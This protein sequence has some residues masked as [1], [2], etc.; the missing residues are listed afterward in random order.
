MLYFARHGL[1]SD[2]LP[3]DAAALLLEGDWPRAEES[4]EHRRTRFSLDTAIDCRYAWIDAAAAEMAADV[5][6][7]TAANGGGDRG[8]GTS[9]ADLNAL[10]LR[11][12]LVK[13]LRLVAFLENCGAE[14]PRGPATL[15]AQR[16]RDEDYARLL[17]DW[18][19]R[20]G[21]ELRV[22]WHASESMATARGPQNAAWRR[23]AGGLAQW[24]STLLDGRQADV[25]PV[26]LCGNAAVLDPLCAEL[27]HR[28]R[29]VYWLFDRFAVGCWWR[30]TRRGV[31]QLTCDASLGRVDAPRT[32]ASIGPI[33]FRGFDL[34]PS[35]DRWLVR[36]AAEQGARQTRLVE[37][38]DRH[39]DRLRPAALV[40]DE[41]ATPLARAAVAA[42]RRHGAVSFVAQHGAPYGRLGFAPLAAD[43]LLAWGESSR[44]RF[45]SWGVPDERIRATGSPRHDADVR[46]YATAIP[47][48]EAIADAPRILLLATSTPAD[49]RPDA[50]AF[51]LTTRTH[52]ELF[53]AA[54]AAVA[55]VPRAELIVK[56]HPRCVADAVY[57][58]TLAEFPDLRHKIVRGGRLTE[59][60]RSAAC[61]LSC[62]SSAGV[63]AA[64][65]GVPVIELLPQGSA[66]LLPAAEW[67]F[68]G[69]ARTEGEIAALLARVLA[70][71]EQSV[72]SADVFGNLAGPASEQMA[73]AI[74][75][76]LCTKRLGA[77]AALAVR[78]SESADFPPHACLTEAAP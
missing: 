8:E 41:D 38:I 14:F 3:A 58:T 36:C 22:V 2:E 6:S 61:A 43:Y 35:L 72:P 13:L 56:L 18:S 10:R 30:W 51:H 64:F 19:D 67:G 24:K 26:V 27:L 39:F 4:A 32:T 44:R 48:A 70:G 46:R 78:S 74:D 7:R 49:D 47:R 28:G 53:R 5:A 71:D 34:G 54:C 1:V 11:Y 69:V 25:R 55:G 42:A 23:W 37:R 45:L 59:L 52:R 20:H 31:R 16:D 73:D 68:A 65:A 60:L 76:S 66:E 12:Y 57:R 33:P 62:G 21:G 15:H 77:A 29:T 63:E 9:P 50:T 17:S 40:V 75:E